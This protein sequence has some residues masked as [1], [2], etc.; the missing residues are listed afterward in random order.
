MPRKNIEK[1]H[2]KSEIIPP[3]ENFDNNTREASSNINFPIVGLGA[4]AGGLD[5]LKTFF[6]N[7]PQNSGMAYIVVAHLSPKAPSLLPEI[8]EKISAIP[9]VKIQDYDGRPVKPNHAYIITP[10]KELHLYNGTIQ[11]MDTFGKT[12]F[13]P[14]NKFF[15]SLALDQKN[16]SAAIVLSGTGTDGTSGIKEIKSN[17][18]L[19][20]VQSEKS[21]GFD[22]MPKSAIHTGL[23]DIV[24]PPE[25]M[26]KK[27]IHYFSN[28]T[29]TVEWDS[30]AIEKEKKWL[31]KIFSILRSRTGHDFSTYK[32]NTILRR[33]S[34]R[35]GLNKIEKQDIYL[36]FLKENPVES[37]ALFRDMLIGVTSFFRDPDSFDVLANQILPE[38]LDN[39]KENAVFR[40]W[41]PGCSTGEE[42]YSL[43]IILNERLE[44]HKKIQF[45]FFGTDI[46]DQAIK[47]AREGV[48]PESISSEMS[49]ERLTRNFTKEGDCYRIKKRIRDC[50]IFSVQN[51]IKDPPFSKL[52]LLCCRNLLIYL[53]TEIQKKLLPLFHYT[54]ENKGILVLG[55][56]ETIG[57]FS[58]LFKTL[59]KKWKIFRHKEVP[60]ALR[61]IVHF[62]SGNHT[63]KQK[64]LTVKTSHMKNKSSVTQATQRAIL[65]QF[66]P[67][68]ILTDAK[69]E[70]IKIQG[71]T[72]KYLEQPSGDPTNNILD[73]ARKGLRIE[74]SSALKQARTSNKTVI[75]KRVSVKTNGDFQFIDLHVNPQKTPEE[76]AGYFLIAFKEPGNVLTNTESEK[77]SQKMS[78]HESSAIDDL[79][80]ELQISRENHQTTIEQLESSNEELKSTNEELQ[81]SNEE[82]QSTNEELESSKEELQSV[83]EELQTVNSEFEDKVTELSLS[84]DDMHNLL[85]SIEVATIFVDNKF[86]IK[87]FT[88]EATQIIN[89]IPS[90]IGRPIKHTVMNSNY[91]RL[92]EDLTEVLS[93]L[94]TKEIE[95][96]TTSGEWYNMRIIPYRTSGNRIDGAILSFLHISDQKNAQEMLKENA[97]ELVRSIFDMNS[98][99]CVVLDGLGKMVLGNTAFSSLLNIN[100]KDIKGKDTLYFLEQGMDNTFFKS[101]VQILIRKKKTFKTKPFSLNSSPKKQQFVIEGK[102]IE[103]D[104]ELPFRF[105]LKFIAV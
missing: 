9:V 88:K 85:N 87:R 101:E 65:N 27:L 59:D 91:N 67:T 80:K 52:N 66:A 105:L 28:P 1:E 8:L 60:Q 32:V 34:R 48:Y 26:P 71:R 86:N 74:L 50:V 15:K 6:L 16:N 37:E 7:V 44:K 43:A 35:M 64:P 25:D 19:V 98:E 11:A 47:K 4:S 31:N 46:D 42:V 22:G 53:D 82:L 69:G 36:R 70:I 12:D 3:S 33:I 54:L 94:N 45:Q 84:H 55:S 30:T 51:V 96:Q 78:L 24:L 81:S 75:K 99:P 79:E 61:R 10:N 18:G 17:H 68:V 20:I 41:V 62:P 38:A 90:D 63:I 2:V 93:S 29:T 23:V 14:I 57:G 89:L 13:Q 77:N 58:N 102:K 83:N 92:I 56:S 76:L 97:K 49:T 40:V 5:A 21:A 39:L 103:R 100:Q 104:T 95:V 73:L 72:G